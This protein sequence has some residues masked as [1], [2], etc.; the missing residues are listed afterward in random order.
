MND[1]KSP[2]DQIK[3]TLPLNAAYVSAVRLTTA[4]VTERLG[5][6]IDEI[7]DIKSAVSEACTY[8]I[9][10]CSFD[11]P[12]NFII[13]LDYSDE[14]IS[15][16][17]LLSNCPKLK[18]ET[19]EMSLLVI[20]ALMDNLDIYYENNTLNILMSKKHIRTLFKE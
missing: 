6:D 15:I 5:F 20:K 8:L 17:L 18:I 13:T 12:N 3:L 7:E 2:N 4:S 10:E 11:K 1:I 19:D 16:S 14:T 9:K